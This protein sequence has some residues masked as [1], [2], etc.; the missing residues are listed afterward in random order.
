MYLSNRIAVVVPA[1]NEAHQLPG[2]L[3]T[4]PEYIDKII[5][6][7]DGS[8]DDTFQIA[9]RIALEDPR[10]IVVHRETRGGVGAAISAGYAKATALETDIAVVMAGDGQMDPSD[11]PALLAPIANGQTDFTKGNRLAHPDSRTKMPR[12][13][14]F[15]TLVLSYATRAVSGYQGLMD[16]QCGYTAIHRRALSA[17]DYTDLYRGYG[18][19]IDLLARLG[20]A[21]M[22][23][24]DVVVRPVYGVG[25]VS[26]LRVHRV[27]L[28]ISWLI[29][30]LYFRRLTTVRR[31]SS[32]SATQKTPA[33][34]DL[35]PR[36]SPSTA[37]E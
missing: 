31:R 25:E 11:L 30:V 16:S 3:Q 12:T 28:P 37:A 13:R 17:I 26:G 20:L 24:M 32:L 29:A 33:I 27:I 4:M 9:N 34:C 10:V 18:Q 35:L 19:P 6:V 7:D 5:V 2:V 36:P 14:Y 21:G 23:S 15:G 8:T 1:R 22:R